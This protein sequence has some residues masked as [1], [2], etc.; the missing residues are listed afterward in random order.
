MKSTTAL[1][2]ILYELSLANIHNSNPY[3]TARNFIKTFLSRMSFNMGAVWIYDSIDSDQ[4]A[5]KKLYSMPTIDIK[6]VIDTKTF[7]KVF[8]QWSIVVLYEPIIGD[9]DRAEGTYI[10]FKLRDLGLLEFYYASKSDRISMDTMYPFEDVVNQFSS[11][12]KSGFDHENLQ[13]QIKQRKL[14]EAS[15]YQNEE[16]Y[17]RIIDNIDL[18]LLE[19]DLDDNITYANDPFL[20]LVGYEQEEILGKNATD[21]FIDDRDS[22]FK[23]AMLHNNKKR[24]MGENGSYEMLIKDKAGNKKWV[25]I[26]GAPSYNADKK[27]VG[28]IGIHLE[29]TNQ[30]KLK[31]EIEFKN[32]KHEKLFEL[33]LDA[34]VSINQQGKIFEWSPQAEVIFGYTRTEILGKK[35]S[36]TIVPMQHRA[37]HDHG[38]KHFMK[39]GE[40][41]VIN[42]RIEI[43]AV[44][45][46]GEEFP[47][48]LTIFHMEHNKQHYFTAFMRDISEMKASKLSMEKA[49]QRQKELNEMKSK[50]ISMTSHE[51]RTPL[52]TIRSNTELIDYQLDNSPELNREKLKKNSNRIDY[53]VDR[54]NQLINNILMIGQMESGKVPYNPKEQDVVSIIEKHVI[55]NLSDQVRKVNFEILGEP[56]DISVD[57]KLFI[58]IISNLVE[59]AL[60][61]SVGKETPDMKLSFEEEQIKIDVRDY[62]MGIP[63]DDQGHLFESFFRASNVGNVQGSGLGLSIVNEFIKLHGGTISLE[64]EE[65]QG[66]NFTIILPK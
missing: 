54:L 60:K 13:E 55:P 5:L 42:N 25:I 15:L 37:S 14:A 9:K 22:R 52:T 36:D 40:G 65:N 23:E 1:L 50:F 63:K 12:L 11:S 57:R 30:K 29:I 2:S 8:E 48:E 61:Y 62:G 18:G 38:M 53:N 6:G 10:Y 4:I 27:I 33:S 34:L 7:E 26:S 16:K 58:H 20:G 24:L 59:N 66:T 32:T 3:D 39:T 21:L 45:K 28:S 56:Y 43:T 46:S 64:S 51:L 19:V 17:K 31:E 49:L 44:R 47:I 41:P 35:L